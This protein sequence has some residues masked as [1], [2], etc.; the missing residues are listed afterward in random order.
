MAILKGATVLNTA[1]TNVATAVILN[2]GGDTPAVGD[3]VQCESEKMSV[4]VV[5]DAT[6]WTVARAA[7]GT[8]AAAHAANAL[9]KIL[10]S[11]DTTTGA[12]VLRWANQY[13]SSATPVRFTYTGESGATVV[14]SA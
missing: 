9:V 14:R 1:L 7:A 2:A 4:T 8:T 5:T 13:D 10:G 3:T 12:M 6:H 11:S